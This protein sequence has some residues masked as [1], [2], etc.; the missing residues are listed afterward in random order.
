MNYGNLTFKI[1]IETIT[2]E[3][4]LDGVPGRAGADGIPGKDGKDGINGLH[5]R[6]GQDGKDGNFDKKNDRNIDLCFS[7]NFLLAGLS[8]PQ[9]P[10]GPVGPPGK[11]GERNLIFITY[12]SLSVQSKILMF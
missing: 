2:G 5:G 8:G 3:P 12:I 4:G 11:K 10:R 7:N 1:I 9:G 6:N